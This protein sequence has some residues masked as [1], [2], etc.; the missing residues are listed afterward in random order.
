M[1]Y[2]LHLPQAI[3]E[4]GQRSNQED[5]IF[6][7]LGHATSDDRLFIVCDGMGGHE[8]GEIASQA[9]VNVLS[10]YISQHH[11]PSEPFSDQL[12]TE[13]LD[14]AYAELDHLDTSEVRKMGTTL[15]LLYLHRGG[16]TAAHIGDSRIY[17]LRPNEGEILYCSR[18]HSLVMDLYQAGEITREEMRTSPQK[19]VITRALSPGSDNR[20][21]AD[22][23]HIANVKPGDY[24]YLCSD[25]MLEQM[26]DEELLA[27][28]ADNTTDSEKRD[29]LIQATANNTDNHS[30]YLIH[31]EAVENEPGDDS[32]LD[33]EQTTRFNAM[34]I[35][36]EREARDA[37]DVSVVV[38]LPKKRKSSE[39]VLPQ[40]KEQSSILNRKPLLIA[41]AAIL[42]ALIFLFKLCSGPA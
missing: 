2:K 26:D 25:G 7:A 8:H 4:L 34:K 38:T 12:L 18:D 30:A 27:L 31:V 17:H 35:Y 42:I 24:F 6:P 23:V 29:A 32:L 20:T 13:A 28:I 11:R 41:I 36:R 9:V 22:I 3:Y 33:D 15:T 16:V 1:K 10:S 5:N 21:R 39:V 14:Q 40:N 37:K 19:N